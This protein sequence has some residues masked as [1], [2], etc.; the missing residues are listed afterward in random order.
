VGLLVITTSDGELLLP[1]EAQIASIKAKRERL[2]RLGV[3]PD[4][5]SLH[6]SETTI[7][8][9]RDDDH[10]NEN[11]N[12]SRLVREA[13]D[14]EDEGNIFILTHTLISF[15]SFIFIN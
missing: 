7:D 1:T 3:T 9:K 10:E 5:I 6:T 15:L 14:D 13:S 12:E 4:F 8:N 11:E 2:R